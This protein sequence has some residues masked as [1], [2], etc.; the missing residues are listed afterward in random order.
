MQGPD[1]L[2]G[3]SEGTGKPLSA[4]VGRDAFH[5][6]FEQL[7]LAVRRPGDHRSWSL[8]RELAWAIDVNDK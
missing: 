4:L 1:A 8:S 7:T 2:V 5:I 3:R 6:P